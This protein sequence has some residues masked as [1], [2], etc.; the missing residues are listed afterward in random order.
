MRQP[1]SW[2]GAVRDE[3]RP[4]FS[5]GLP[6]AKPGA[7]AG[8]AKADRPC[9]PA[10]GSV[11]ATTTYQ[12]AKPALVIHAFSPS[13]TQESPSRRA[14]VRMPLGSEPAPGSVRPKPPRAPAASSGRVRALSSAL[15]KRESGQQHTELLTLIVTATDGEMRA[16]SSTARQ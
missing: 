11:T 15:A 4:S 9:L 5:S 2:S 14:R 12:R 10:S 3:Q 6:T 8:T 13:S 1:V 7:S 16:S